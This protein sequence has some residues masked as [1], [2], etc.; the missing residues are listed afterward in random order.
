M[1]LDIK[2]NILLYLKPKVWRDSDI[3]IV[4]RPFGGHPGFFLSQANKK[5]PPSEIII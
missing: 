3:T 1:W 4:P 2:I 5:F